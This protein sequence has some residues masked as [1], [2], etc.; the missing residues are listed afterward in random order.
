MNQQ[1]AGALFF[2][3]Q[4]Q[5]QEDLSPYLRV[6][7]PGQARQIN[8]QFGLQLETEGVGGTKFKLS[9]SGDD[10]KISVTL[11]ALLEQP[12][13]QLLPMRRDQPIA[14]QFSTEIIVNA[15]AARKQALKLDMPGGVRCD[16][17]GRLDSNLVK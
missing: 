10:F 1:I 17:K 13:E 5:N 16:W 14:V 6:L 8:S 3:A 12:R 7:T 9:R 2:A 4:N 11:N 15:D